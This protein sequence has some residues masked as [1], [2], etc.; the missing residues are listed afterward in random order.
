MEDRVAVVTGAS[1]GLGLETA[2]LFCAEGASTVLVDVNKDR[3]AE[4]AREITESGGRA[5]FVHG[6]VSSR[7][8]TENAVERAEQ[9]FGRLDA[10][11]ANAGILGTAS[12]R[13]TETVSEAAWDEIIGVNLTGTFNTIISAIPA[14]R[15]AGGGSISATSSVASKYAV[16]Y[17]AAYSATKA[18]IDA[19]IRSLAVEFAPEKIRL[20]AV[21]VGSM[22]SNLGETL[23]A[24]R[25]RDNLDIQRP[26]KSWKSRVVRPGRDGV[27]EAARVH[28]FLSSRLA[29][30]VS[31]E[32][33][34]A[35]GAFSLWNGM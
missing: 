18:G 26:D 7:G 14:L 6:D 17:A 32:S 19:L 29:E 33:V 3:G 25:S 16:L 8:D 9:E 24:G 21:C 23:G 4:A 20:N 28:L 34:V 12:F 5:V 11:V 1:S 15:R 13:R 35:D 10:V 22:R 31:G 30:Y 27:A 2:R